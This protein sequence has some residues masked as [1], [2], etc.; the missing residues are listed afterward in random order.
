MKLF[1]YVMSERTNLCSQ[2]L[3]LFINSGSVVGKLRSGNRIYG[4]NEAPS[5]FVWVVARGNYFEHR[6]CL[7]AGMRYVRD[8]QEEDSIR[9]A[10]TQACD[11]PAEVS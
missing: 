5:K 1:T 11:Y 8:L 3:P 2:Q 4:L 9:L 6:R 10:A 7:C